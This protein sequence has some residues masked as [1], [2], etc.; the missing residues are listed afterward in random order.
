MPCQATCTCTS[1]SQTHAT[2]TAHL[3]ALQHQTSADLARDGAAHI[4]TQAGD[5]LLTR[6]REAV[7]Q[8]VVL[9]LFVHHTLHLC[10]ALLGHVRVL[11][12]LLQTPA[13]AYA[14]GACVPVYV[15]MFA[16]ALMHVCMTWVWR[17]RPR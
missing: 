5:V 7:V 15:C 6:V 1:L 3:Q 17:Y 11:C 9:G 13:R 12:L 14:R 16:H 2:N 4:V 10:L 8:T